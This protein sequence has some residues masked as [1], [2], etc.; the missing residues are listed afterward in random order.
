MLLEPLSNQNITIRH[1]YCLDLVIIINEYSNYTILIYIYDIDI[2]IINIHKKI[3]KKVKDIKS[4]K[5]VNMYNSNLYIE[6]VL[7]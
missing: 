2:E 1:Q 7:N 4:N 6:W 5:M 3:K